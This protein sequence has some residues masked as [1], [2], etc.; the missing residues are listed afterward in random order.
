MDSN[1]A[2]SNG[3]EA[4]RLF[5]ERTRN[6]DEHRQRTTEPFSRLEAAQPAA[7]TGYSWL[8]TSLFLLSA[9][10]CCTNDKSRA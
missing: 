7:R 5:G 6:E 3:Q 1:N 9:L 10:A 8:H 4:A 2:E